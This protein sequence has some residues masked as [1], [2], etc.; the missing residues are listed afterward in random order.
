MSLRPEKDVVVDVDQVC[1][2]LAPSERAHI[3]RADRRAVIAEAKRV[4]GDVLGYPSAWPYRR[5]VL[6]ALD[7]IL[8]ET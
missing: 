6:A 5:D 1:G 4:V 2:S 3:I 7:G 8:K